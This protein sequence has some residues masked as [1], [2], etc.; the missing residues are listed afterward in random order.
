MI[1]MPESV[2]GYCEGW[3]V[4]LWFC[5]SSNTKTKRRAR[6][7]VGSRLMCAAC[8]REHERRIGIVG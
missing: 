3:A 8:K 4:G 6:Y 7:Q 1:T 2:S 5:Q